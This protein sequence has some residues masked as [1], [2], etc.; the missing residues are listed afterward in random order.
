M[1]HITDK[2]QCCG[3][4]SCAQKCPKH[5][6]KMRED[7][8]GFLYPSFDDETCIDCGLCERVCPVLNQDKGREPLKCYAAKNPNEFVRATSASGGIFLP[9]AESVIREGGVVFGARFNEKWEVVHASVETKDDL[10]VFQGSKYVQSKVGSSF[11]DTELYLKGDRKVLFSGTPC[12]IAALHKFLGKEYD[13]LTTIDVVC[14]GVPSPKLWREY[15]SQLPMENVRYVLFKD[16]SSGW[17][18]YSF[19]LKADDGSVLLTEKA[20]ENKYLS[21]FIRNISLRPS[22]YNCHSKAGRSHSDI[23]L[24]DFWGIETV[25]PSLDD[26]KGTSVIMCNTEKGKRIIESLSLNAEEIQY[27]EYSSIPSNSCFTYSTN[28]PECRISF[29][30]EY[31]NSG[32]SALLNLPK[33]ARL[34]LY[35]RV[36]KRLLS[37]KP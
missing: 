30:N 17:R 11:K 15:I 12:Q 21:A 29:W 16:K 9:I 10:R 36:L 22:C 20:S 19:T 13:N 6:I 4:S 27:H 32:I 33:P 1:I 37:Y 7:N 26:N 5:C 35:I 8:E 3:C 18:N 14:H 34:P 23:T 2:Y 25:L 28:E 31:A 24:A